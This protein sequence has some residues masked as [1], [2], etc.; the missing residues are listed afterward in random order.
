MREKK[1]GVDKTV[2]YKVVIIGLKDSRI[3]VK[4]FADPSSEN[5]EGG[6]MQI[7]FY[8]SLKDRLGNQC[9]IIWKS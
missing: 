3:S 4:V 5:V 6:R 7:G 8:I 2:V 1:Q 9:P